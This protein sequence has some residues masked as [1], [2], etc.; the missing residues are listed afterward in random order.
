[1]TLQNDIYATSTTVYAGGTLFLNGSHSV[2]GNLAVATKWRCFVGG[3]L[4]TINGNFNASAANTT[5]NLSI[6]SA[7][8]FGHIAATGTA[9][10]NA[11]STLNLTVLSSNIPN[12]TT[13]TIISGAGG[14]GPGA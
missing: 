2:T 5:L 4:L 13:F 10:L 7:S 8:V 3:E 11:S 9:A 6:N 12:G 14:A 1:V